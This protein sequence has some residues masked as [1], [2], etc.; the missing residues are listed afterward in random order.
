[1][2]VVSVSCPTAEIMGISQSNTACA[3]FSSLKAHRSSME[4]PPRPTI[5]TSTFRR[6]NMRIP[7]TMLSAASSPCTM[8]GYRRICTYGFLRWV[9]LIISRTA[10]PVDAV[11]TPSVRIY[12]GIGFLYSGANIPRSKSSSFKR[13][14]RSNSAPSPSGVIRFA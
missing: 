10:A 4:P 2:I 5:I 12:F 9:I 1:M 8:A 11:T 6:S 13:W 14:K 7:R 3:T